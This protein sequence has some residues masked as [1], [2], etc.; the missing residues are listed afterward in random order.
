[1]K[2]QDRLTASAPAP[3]S[4]SARGAGGT[5]TLSLS[6]AAQ[7]VARA[8][9][10]R[11]TARPM[12]TRALYFAPQSRAARIRKLTD[13]SSRKS[14]LSANSDTEPMAKAAANSMPKY[15]RL[16][17]ATRRTTRRRPVSVTGAF[18]AAL[19]GRFDAD[20]SAKLLCQ[21]L[22]APLWRRNRLA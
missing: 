8:G 14:M 1:M 19:L 15:P 6:H 9:I 21:V 10:S 5:G 7:R 16:S 4:E 13:A 3:V 18:I 17:R 20:Y 22:A 11:M 12:P 2:A